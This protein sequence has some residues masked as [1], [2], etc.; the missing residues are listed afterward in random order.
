MVL[1]S[2]FIR[3]A[4]VGT[5]GAIVHVSTV[6]LLVSHLQIH[7]LSANVLGF[8]LGFH[9]S[10][11]GHRYWTFSET[12][13]SHQVA[14]PRLLVLQIFNFIA[15]ETMFYILLSLHLPYV[16]ALLIVLCIL[17]AMTFTVSRLWI[18]TTV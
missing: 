11:F 16:L 3:F 2:R 8:L 6:M 13:V 14:F 10:Y 18:F 7:P 12:N 9:V 4:L 1:S 15:N 5:L 17:P